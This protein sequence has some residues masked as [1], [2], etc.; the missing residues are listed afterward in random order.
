M[1]PIN[2]ERK[3]KMKTQTQTQHTPGPWKVQRHETGDSRRI[4]ITGRP[5]MIADVDW[6]A[7]DENTA[8]AALIASAPDLLAA[9]EQCLPLVDKHRRMALGE[10]DTAAMNARQA[11]AK[12]EGGEA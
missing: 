5:G 6:N 1:K 8:N 12:A 2:N 4:T 7:P 10:G 3:T 9:L 11:I